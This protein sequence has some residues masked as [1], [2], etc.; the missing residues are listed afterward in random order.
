MRALF[1]TVAMLVLAACAEKDAP[2]PPVAAQAPVNEPAAP[3]DGPYFDEVAAAVGIDFFHYLG[4]TG[5]YFFPEIAASG[6]AVFDYDNDGDLDIYAVQ[7]AM[8]DATKSADDSIFKPRHALPIT[9]RLYRNELV[10]TGDFR[11][12]DVTGQAGLADAGYGMGVVTGD[13]DN[14]G[15]VDLVVTNFGP[16]RFYENLGNGKF[17]LVEAAL[18]VDEAEEW[19]TSASLADVDLDG[20]LDVFATNY[21][22]FTVGN[23][24]R[25]TSANGQREYCGPNTFP[26]TIDRLWRNDGDNVFVDITREAL[27]SSAA[28]NGLGTSATDFDG[29]G[30]VDIYVA[31]DLMENRLWTQDDDGRF[32][33]T[34]LMAGSAYNGSGA[35]EA[36]MGVTAGDFDGDGDEDLFMTHLAAETNT[37]YLN[38][39]DGNFF[40]ITDSANLAAT[41]LRLTGFGTG[42]IDYDNDGWLDLF[43]A[44]G[45]VTAVDDAKADAQFPYGQI[46]Q[47]LRNVDGRFVDVSTVAGESFQWRDTSRGAAFG[48][49]DNDGDIDIVVSNANAPLRVLRN[50]VGNEQGWLRVTLEG[51]SSNRDAAGTRVALTLTD[52]RVLWR[53]AHTDGSYLSASDI[54]VHFGLGQNAAREVRVIWP[55]GEDERWPLDNAANVAIDIVQGKGITQ[56]QR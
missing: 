7:G 13:T 39:G 40:D 11:F 21:I 19:T 46:N 17:A 35:A 36:S 10:P 41:S 6:V 44:N 51:T 42:W 43:I 50:R 14:D 48:D 8:L 29:D 26:P 27:I 47:L 33:D 32:S 18:Q 53:R 23:N 25:C 16:N 28:G 24:I 56:R 1:V 12:T 34:A 38:D 5:D 20:D 30:D 49:L 31:N 52:D 55:G 22:G 37:L 9:N 15:D 45:A 54:R 2:P 4:A 3:I